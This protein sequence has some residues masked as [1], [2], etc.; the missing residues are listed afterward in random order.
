MN[1]EEK[2]LIDELES[3][4]A[5]FLGVNPQFGRDWVGKF[6]LRINTKLVDCEIYST[7]VHL[8]DEM[9]FLM[10]HRIIEIQGGKCYLVD[11]NCPDY[12]IRV[13]RS[14]DINTG[15]NTYTVYQRVNGSVQF[16]QDVDIVFENSV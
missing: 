7:A 1:A 5:S 12:T 16:Q 2:K 6:Q 13:A 4:V 10:S 9:S 8:G 3:E 15:K 14:P 11:Y